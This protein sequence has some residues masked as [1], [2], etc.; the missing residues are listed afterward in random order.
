MK[1]FNLGVNSLTP[2]FSATTVLPTT[3]EVVEAAVKRSPQNKLARLARL[4]E[5]RLG[6]PT[7]K[8]RWGTLV[9]AAKSAKVKKLLSRSRSDESISSDAGNE[10]TG[11][12]EDTQ[13]LGATQ[14]PL[15]NLPPGI[16]RTADGSSE[17]I[18]HERL[19]SGVSGTMHLDAAALV[20]QQD[21]VK[22]PS[23]NTVSFHQSAVGGGSSSSPSHSSTET[24]PPPPYSQ[25]PRPVPTTVSVTETTTA[26]SPS[27]GGSGSL[28][29]LAV[30]ESSE[31]LVD[32]GR[33][34]NGL[35]QAPRLP[36]I[37]PVNRHMAA[38]WL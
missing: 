12:S 29:P 11:D 34:A 4:A 30:S 35:V 13:G 27:S 21:P 36:G 25:W 33:P 8:K 5:A 1:G 19:G 31:P 37:Q 32:S 7:N 6:R 23:K 18:R 28:P 16:L 22:R 10:I 14:T 15:Q 24:E 9:E 26:I 3:T 38:G 20:S 2:L 17:G